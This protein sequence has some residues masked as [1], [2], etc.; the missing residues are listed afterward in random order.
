MKLTFSQWLQNEVKDIGIMWKCISERLNLA[1]DRITWR[2]QKDSFSYEEEN[3][4]RELIK[5]LKQ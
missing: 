3:K 1:P 2:V 4:I 5:E